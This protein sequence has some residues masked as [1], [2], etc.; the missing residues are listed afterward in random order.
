M[1]SILMNFVRDGGGVLISLGGN[2]SSARYNSSLGALLPARLKSIQTFAQSG[3]EGKPMAIPDLKHELFVPFQRGGAQEFSGVRWRSLFGVEKIVDGAKVLL[4]LENGAPVLLERQIGKGRVLLLLGPVDYAWSNFP[5]QSI[6]MPW[7]QRSVRYLGGD[8][9]LGGKRVSGEVDQD[10]KIKLADIPGELAL[11][12][13]KGTIGLQREGDKVRFQPRY[14]G[15][16]TLRIHGA[17]PLAQVVV[18]H[19]ASESDVRVSTPLMEVAAQIQPDQFIQKRPLLKWLLW[20]GFLLL[21]LQALL[22]FFLTKEGDDVQ[23]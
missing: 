17:P 3:E 22:S 2:V 6:F 7:V 8:S 13:V 1:A 21:L 5:F 4:S 9:S 23:S 16:Y 18:N 11:E 14:A 12:G 20:F 19:I 15:A 10:M